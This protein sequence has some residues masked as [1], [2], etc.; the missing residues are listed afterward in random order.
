MENR[1]HALTAG[2]FA[3][4][5]G[6]ALLAA[7]WWFSQDRQAVKEV[8]LVSR[9]NINGLGVQSRVRFR[10]I[11]AG[12]VSAIRIDPED[13]RNILITAK[14]A[15]NL[16]LTRGTTASIGTLGVTGLA[17][18][19]LEDRGADPAPLAGVEGQPPR[20]VLEPGLMDQ[21]ADRALA[22]AE[23]FGAMAERLEVMFDD[24]AAV[25]FRQTLLRLE[26]AATGMDRTFA[27]APQLLEAMRSVFNRE[28][29]AR[30]AA[31]LAHAE[32]AG[33]EA[34]PAVA[35]L[36]GLLL[37][38]DGMVQRLDR[39]AVAAGDGVIEGTLPRLNDLLRELTVTSRRLGRLIEEVEASPQLLFTGRGERAPGPGEAGFDPA[40][41]GG[42]R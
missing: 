1:A 39:T 4:L 40:A 38:I 14:V 8:V 33:A 12:T 7:L 31:L 21:I 41:A 3:L 5:L 24:E 19:A 23:R 37:R 34:G 17:Y 20:I 15:D 36:R 27:E 22:A 35:E 28:N 32:R 18:V 11:N 6:A 42:T 10:G 2:L 25:R 13:P 30:L 29:L 26:S 9:G 16:P